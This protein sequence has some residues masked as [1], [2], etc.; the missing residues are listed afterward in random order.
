M[1][2]WIIKDFYWKAFSLLMAIGIWLTVRHES[3]AE[4]ST[5]AD[6]KSNTYANVPITVVSANTDVQQAKITPQTVTAIVSGS[7]DII[8]QLEREQIHAFVD[9]TGLNSAE[10]LPRNVE[11]SLPRG[12]TVIEIDPAQ[13]TVTLPKRP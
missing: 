8:N 12:A 3:E 6:L 13:A 2:D 10:N 9:L 11:I 5:P 4:I 1:R 7:P